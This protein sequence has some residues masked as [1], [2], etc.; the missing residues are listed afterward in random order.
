MKKTIQK[1]FESHT[2]KNIFLVFCELINQFKIC[3]VANSAEFNL[4]ESKIF[5]INLNSTFEF[6]FQ[7]I[8]SLIRRKNAK[9]IFISLFKKTI[10]KYRKHQKNKFFQI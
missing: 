2:N 10:S 1:E 6:Q 3:F 7:S 8:K 9:Q 4:F 5:A